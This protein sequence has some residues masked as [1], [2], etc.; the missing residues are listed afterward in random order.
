MRCVVEM[1]ST[2][3]AKR[4]ALAVLLLAVLGATAGCGYLRRR[5]AERPP[6]RKVSPPIA[7]EMMRD[8]PTLLILD[9]RPPEAFHG[10]TGH[11]YRAYNIPERR[12]S[13]RLIE[14]SPYRNDTFLVYCD[15]R[16]CGDAG[17]AV[18]VS[19]G[20]ESAVLIDG[21]IDGW[22][23]NGFRTVLPA[24]LVGRREHSAQGEGATQAPP[25]VP[26]PVLQME[27]D[28]HLPVQRP[29]SPSP[30]LPR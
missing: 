26:P 9:L 10:D 17:M 29:P 3:R 8:T 24:D 22:I 27:T 5:A 7:F 23:A 4:C 1:P 18:L 15:T 30:T 13:Y 25:L 11:I 14:L 16:E 28:P 12:L 2:I 21:G 19:S 20:F 6:Y